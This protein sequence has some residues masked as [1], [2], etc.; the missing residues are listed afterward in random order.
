ML[1]AVHWPG[2]LK[3]ICLTCGKRPTRIEVIG[4]GLRVPTPSVQTTFHP[5]QG[6]RYMGVAPASVLGIHPNH[7]P[8]KVFLALAVEEGPVVA[9]ASRSRRRHVSPIAPP[10]RSRAPRP[11]PTLLLP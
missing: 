4:D 2:V 5:P 3:N 10:A 1:K 11:T 7:P 6:P 9:A 8:P